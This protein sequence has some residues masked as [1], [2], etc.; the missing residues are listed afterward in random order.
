LKKSLFDLKTLNFAT[1]FCRHSSDSDSGEDY[2]VSDDENDNPVVG[3]PVVIAVAPVVVAQKVHQLGPPAQPLLRPNGHQWREDGE[4][5]VDVGLLN[6]RTRLIWPGNADL[7]GDPLPVRAELDYF[8]L[9][10]PMQ[11]NQSTI[12]QILVRS[13][14]AVINESELL[15]YF[16][17]RLNMTLDRSRLDI[18]EYW[19][20]TPREGSTFSPPDYGKYGMTRRRF[21]YISSALRFS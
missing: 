7:L 9:L 11:L 8:R 16:G 5:S 6:R 17:I 13:G 3:N 18:R 1:L 2:G 21:Q 20:E 15:K 10:Y 4:V 12:Q 19:E 14:R